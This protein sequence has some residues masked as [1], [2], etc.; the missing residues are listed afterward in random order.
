MS[1]GIPLA[2]QLQVQNGPPVGNPSI[3]IQ[4]QPASMANHPHLQK[5]AEQNQAFLEQAKKAARQPKA[6]TA[7]AQT[8]AAKEQKAAYDAS[9]AGEKERIKMCR[10]LNDY[11][12]T[13]QQKEGF[14]DFKW[15]ADYSPDLSSAYLKSTLEAVRLILNTKHVRTGVAQAITGIAWIGSKV[16]AFYL[17]SVPGSPIDS[18]ICNQFYEN[19]KENVETGFFDDEVDQL[20][21]EWAEW[22]SRGPYWRTCEKLFNIGTE[23]IE[24]ATPILSTPEVANINKKN[25]DL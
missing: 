1:A 5:V 10:L 2:S 8:S 15:K 6:A 24:A 12:K 14:E 25:S 7:K 21:V 17:A 18:R 4:E 20:A 3:V 13:H 9:E 16:A 23:T 22:L 19:V 11:R